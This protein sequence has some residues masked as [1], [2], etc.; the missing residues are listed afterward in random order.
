[1]TRFALVLLAVSLTACGYNTDEYEL[2]RSALAP[3]TAIVGGSVKGINPVS[4]HLIG[5]G[6]GAGSG[7]PARALVNP[8][9]DRYEPLRIK[10]Y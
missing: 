10:R 5:T 9:Y 1:M 4:G 7:M 2:N 6:I 3:G 8:K